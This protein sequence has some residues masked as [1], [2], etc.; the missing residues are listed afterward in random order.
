[1]KENRAQKWKISRLESKI[2]KL[3]SQNSQLKKKLK[4]ELF[5]C[6]R[7]VHIQRGRNRGVL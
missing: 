3:E 2:D 5:S 7:A 4:R 6:G 1:M